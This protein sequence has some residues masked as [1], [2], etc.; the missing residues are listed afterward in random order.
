MWIR[1][2]YNKDNVESKQRF[3]ID[4]VFPDN[5]NEDIRQRRE[6]QMEQKLLFFDIDGTLITEGPGVLPESTRQA[7]KQAKEKGHFLFVNTGRTLKSLPKKITELGFSGYVC[8]CGTNIF[9]NGEELLC[10][11]LDHELC[12]QIAKKVGEYQVPVFY[13]AMDAIYSDHRMQ[14]HPWVREI[15]KAMDMHAADIEEI[16]QDE[17]KVYEKLVVIL[18]PTEKNQELKEYLSKYFQCIDRGHDMYEMIQKGYSKATGIRFLCEYLG[19][20]IEDCYVFGD[21]ENDRAMLEA[22]PNS[23]AMGNAKEAVKSICS[24]VTADIEEDGIY[25]AMKHFGL[26]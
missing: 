24:Y 15:E 18:E 2:L 8:G 13:E 3:R 26:I 6:K 16:F 7:V 25:K 17:T 11:R 19:K 5:Y 20:S 23:I 1:K 10:S 21:S 14:E 12:R 9:L 22:V 4:G